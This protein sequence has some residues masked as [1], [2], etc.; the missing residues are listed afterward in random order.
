MCG[1]R[2]APAPRDSLNF[3]RTSLLSRN[4]CASGTFTIVLHAT[5]SFTYVSVIYGANF[6]AEAFYYPQSLPFFQLSRA[7]PNFFRGR[8]RP[9]GNALLMARQSSVGWACGWL[10]SAVFWSWIEKKL[11][12]PSPFWNEKWNA[13][14]HSVRTHL[15]QFQSPWSYRAHAL[16][17][18]VKSSLT[19]LDMHLGGWPGHDVDWERVHVNIL[20]PHKRRTRKDGPVVY[21]ADAF[22]SRLRDD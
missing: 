1:T 8:W 9:R 21:S 17:S 12:F 6:P 14:A 15:Q 22:D 10:V 19:Q 13:R 16:S 4:E 5:S 2:E 11:W 3:R 18:V 20:P 7:E